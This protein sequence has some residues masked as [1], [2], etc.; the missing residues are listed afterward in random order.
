MINAM[1]NAILSLCL[2][3]LFGIQWLV[4][5]LL[6]LLWQSILS[7]ALS[8]TQ[9]ILFLGSDWLTDRLTR[10]RALFEGYQNISSS[11]NTTSGDPPQDQNSTG[12]NQPGMNG[13]PSDWVRIELCRTDEISE[14]QLNDD[15]GEMGIWEEREQF[16]TT[17]KEIKGRV[18]AWLE[19]PEG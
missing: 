10:C 7:I 3:S 1:I 4:L 11:N 19:K 14:L 2:T 13:I 15:S 9:A 8:I 12:G 16:M 6:E 18:S 5:A 17:K